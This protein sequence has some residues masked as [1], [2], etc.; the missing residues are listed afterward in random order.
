MKHLPKLPKILRYLFTALCG[1]CL[2]GAVLMCVV[3]I[4]PAPPLV[5]FGEVSVGDVTFAP[6]QGTLVLHPQGMTKSILITKVHGDI[7]WRPEDN[8]T[9][10]AMLQRI[11]LPAAILSALAYALMFDLFRRLFYQVEHGEGFT[12]KT[13]RL[14]RRLGGIL[15]FFA[16]AQAAADSWMATAIANMLQLQQ[17]KGTGVSVAIN[18]DPSLF[19]GSL[20]FTGLIVLALSEVFRQGLILKREND[21]TV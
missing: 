5:H 17:L 20:F 21:L 12:E 14:V 7:S 11:I 16:L 3:M 8:T 18:A 1:F 10:T 15:I 6:P 2:L 13:V 4:F 19:G 9:F